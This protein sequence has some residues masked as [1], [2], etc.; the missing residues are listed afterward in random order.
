MRWSILNGIS[1]SKAVTS[2]AIWFVL[3][4]VVAKLIVKSEQLQTAN[5]FGVTFKVNMSLPFQWHLLFYASCFFLF[6]SIIYTLICPEFVKSHVNYSEF[7]KLG[8]TQVQ[9]NAYLVNLTKPFPF[10]KKVSDETLDL[11][12]SYL[13]HYTTSTSIPTN[14]WTN[15]AAIVEKS[16]AND[17]ENDAFYYVLGL[18]DKKNSLFIWLTLISYI[19]GFACLATIAYQNFMY[20]RTA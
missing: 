19:F 11:V 15:M 5:I 6:S 17:N 8:K 2:V 7:K 13:S 18:S 12:K 20:V 10:F 1:Q 3:V 9:L 4:P 16:A 14:E